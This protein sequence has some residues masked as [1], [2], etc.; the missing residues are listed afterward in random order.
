MKITV[1]QKVR[2][3]DLID[4]DLIVSIIE[5]GGIFGNRSLAI[6]LRKEKSVE[7]FKRYEC[8][9]SNG[10]VFISLDHFTY[11]IPRYSALPPEQYKNVMVYVK[12][13]EH[14]DNEECPYSSRFVHASITK[15]VTW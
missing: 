7:E 5:V 3:I 4:P 13:C 15:S 2:L 9:N 12:F 10:V 11:H 14:D 1:V 6:A 8:F